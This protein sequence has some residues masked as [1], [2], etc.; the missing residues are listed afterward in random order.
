MARLHKQNVKG[1]TVDVQPLRNKTDIRNMIEALEMTSNGRRDALLFKI[2]I[3]TGL[4]IGDIVALRITD[5]KGRASFVI[6]EGK[7]RKPR[8]VYI[9][10]VAGD[11]AEYLDD[12]GEDVTGWLFPSRKGSGHI[13]TTQA[14]RILTQAGEMIGRSDV[15]T[16]TL[17]K[18]FGYH[19]YRKTRDVATLMEIFNHES[20]RTTLRYI[21]VEAEE[22]ENSLKDFR[23]F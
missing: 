9:G 2:G 19:Y 18:T 15:G 1:A 20:Q 14:Y 10:A 8:R 16:H 17:R 13:S 5:V 11:I 3:T 21:G 12:R 22:I 4:R 6:R 7:T 23:L